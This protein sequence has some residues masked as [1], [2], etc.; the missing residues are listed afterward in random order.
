MKFIEQVGKIKVYAQKNGNKDITIIFMNGMDI[1]VNDS[2]FTNNIDRAIGKL[3]IKV[4]DIYTLEWLRKNVYMEDLKEISK[5][6]YKADDND[7]F[8]RIDDTRYFKHFHKSEAQFI[9]D[10]NGLRIVDQ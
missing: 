3:F 8:C 7:W 10:K 2:Y 9:T 6:T 5:N 4:F 1:I